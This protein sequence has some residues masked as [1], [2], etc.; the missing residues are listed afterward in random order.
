MT[1]TPFL[2]TCNGICMTG[3]DVGVPSAEIAYAHPDCPMHGVDAEYP[4]TYEM[5]P[6]PTE[7]TR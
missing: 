3:H 1:F 5:P 4:N 7:E 6:F 2:P